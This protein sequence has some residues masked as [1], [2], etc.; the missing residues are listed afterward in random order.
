MSSE[1]VQTFD[2]VPLLNF[3]NDYE[4]LNAYPF[5]IRKKANHRVI[6][7]SLNGGYV[8]V[9]LNSKPYKKHRPIAL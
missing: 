2:F 7:E 9:N 3:E 6:S 1:E 8:Q 4:I 5:T